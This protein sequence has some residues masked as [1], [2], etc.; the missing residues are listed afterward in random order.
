MLSNGSIRRGSLSE[1]DA[2]A[3]ADA[4]RKRPTARQPTRTDGRPLADSCLLNYPQV[5]KYM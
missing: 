3:L 5:Q 1:K 4:R 2:G